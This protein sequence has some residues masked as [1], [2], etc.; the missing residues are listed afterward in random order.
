VTDVSLTAAEVAAVTAGC[1]VSG[2]ERERIERWSI[3]SRAVAPGEVFIAIRGE[4]FDGHEFTQAAFDRGAV[5]A[6]VETGRSGRVPSG[7]L[8]IEVNDTTRALQDVAREVRRRSGAQVVAITGSAGKTT[9]KELTADFLSSRFGVFRNKGN[10][11]NHIGLPLSLLELRTRPDVAVVELGMNHAGEIRTL[12]GIAEPDVRVWT[13]VGDA[14]LGFFE[15]ADRIAD[16]KAEILERARASD[17]LIANA[18]DPRIMSRIGTFAGRTVTFG[19]SDRA[20]VRA[21]GVQHRGLDGMAALLT[22]PAGSVHVST[23]LLGIGNLLNLLAA[24]AVASE[25]DVPLDEIA[26]RSSQVKPAAHRGELLRM[27]GG[28][29]LIDDSYN[30]SPSALMRALETV[31]AST[32]SARKVAVLG[33]MLELGDHST[34]LHEQC[35]RAAGEASLDL[36]IAVGGDPASHL[37]TAARSA[38]MAD[39]AVVY[40]RTSEEAADIALEKIRPG[41]LVLVKGS[42]GIHTDVVVDRLKVEFA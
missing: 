20:V 26:R 6:V 28:I 19:L 3:D 10:L 7:R 16:A 13:N 38:G 34:R 12:V 9:T 18:D 22:T 36:L 25:F 32:G 35:G 11:N 39:T 14:H 29:T 42:H 37:A 41:D 8:A 40:A 4:R 1:I 33:E 2:D 21:S 15:S 24:A 5:G 30:S 31:R 23:P 27:P 17:R